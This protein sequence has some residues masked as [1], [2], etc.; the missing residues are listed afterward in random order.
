MLTIL[1]LQFTILVC[2]PPEAL[3]AQLA[4]SHCGCGLIDLSS[5]AVF[6]T[7]E[8]FDDRRR[9]LLLR[10]HNNLECRLFF[11]NSFEYI[12]TAATVGPHSTS[13]TVE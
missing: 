4:A 9:G 6:I 1:A 10:L 7:F 8:R 3:H 2:T 11:P 13:Q 5:P 12:T